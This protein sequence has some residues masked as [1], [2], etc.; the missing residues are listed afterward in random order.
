M[1]ALSILAAL[2]ISLGKSPVTGQNASVPNRLSA[3]PFTFPPTLSLHF[4]LVSTAFLPHTL[5]LD[6]NLDV[7]PALAG[8][9]ES[10]REVKAVGLRRR[11]GGMG[12]D[13]MGTRVDKLGE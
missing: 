6:L 11:G 4:T 10:L 5:E 12:A 1:K 13:M 8:S 9:G 7:Q 3:I 2:S